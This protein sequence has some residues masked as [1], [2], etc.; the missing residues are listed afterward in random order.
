M[1]T[2]VKVDNLKC[3]GCAATIKKN[4]LLIKGI[5]SLEVIPE[6]EEVKI[7]HDDALSLKLAKDELDRL[8]YPEQGTT[9]GLEKLSKNVKSYLSCA[10]GK[11]TKPE[12]DKNQ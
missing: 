3:G 7:N 12:D 9:E 8:G 5:E 11:L 10:I 4:L 1:E 2:I 6:N